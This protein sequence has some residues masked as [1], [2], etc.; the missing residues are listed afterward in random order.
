MN[1]KSSLTVDEKL[2]LV[3]FELDRDAHITVKKELCRACTTRPCLNICAAENYKWDE[4]GDDLIFNHE[5]CLECGACRIICP[6]DAIDWSY[7]RGGYGVRYR[8]G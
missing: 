2:A 7:P 4:E 3:V 5:G 1:G 8:F 6:R